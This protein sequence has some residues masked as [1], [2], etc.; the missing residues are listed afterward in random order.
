MGN[1]TIGPYGDP[2]LPG[3]PGPPGPPGPG[4]HRNRTNGETIYGP[5]GS[6]GNIGDKVCG[7]GDGQ[8]LFPACKRNGLRLP[9]ENCNCCSAVFPFFVLFVIVN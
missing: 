9:H 1:G 5:P 6:K 7:R 2:G 3:A 8:K 4:Y